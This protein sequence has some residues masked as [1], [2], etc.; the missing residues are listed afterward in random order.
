MV[1]F[2]PSQLCSRWTEEAEAKSEGDRKATFE[3]SMDYVLQRTKM[4]GS[5]L[6]HL[7]WDCD[8]ITKDS[9]GRLQFAEDNG[10]M[11]SWE[12]THA[13]S[14]KILSTTECKLHSC[15]QNDLTARES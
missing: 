2:L 5:I 12:L 4:R 1:H 11:L 9:S 3:D 6:G 14:H 8:R 7:A 15:N 10:R 13:I